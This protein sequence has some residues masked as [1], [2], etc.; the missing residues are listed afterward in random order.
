MV[1]ATGV[2]PS[3]PG[4][5]RASMYASNRN[6][7]PLLPEMT[8]EEQVSRVMQNIRQSN[9]M[10]SILSQIRKSFFTVTTKSIAIQ[11]QEI[12]TKSTKAVVS[13]KKV[14]HIQAPKF[15]RPSQIPKVHPA[16]RFIVSLASKISKILSN[17]EKNPNILGDI[18]PP[19]SK[20]IKKGYKLSTNKIYGNNKTVERGELNKLENL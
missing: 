13:D 14:T 3:R 8:E 6:I 15:Q 2:V 18:N 7:A 11:T 1:G 9:Y 4:L 10:L 19:I 5:S 20:T 16:S 17:L 12:K